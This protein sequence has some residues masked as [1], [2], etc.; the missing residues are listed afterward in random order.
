MTTQ[1]AFP[2]KLQQPNHAKFSVRNAHVKRYILLCF[3]ILEF[4]KRSWRW[5]TFWHERSQELLLY[6][7][8]I[9]DMDILMNYYFI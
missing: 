8:Y 7:V 3:G 4:E 2:M 5:K 9:F 1:K 6:L